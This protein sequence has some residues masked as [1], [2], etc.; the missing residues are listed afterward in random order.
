M[1]L[2]RVQ[3]RLASPKTNWLWLQT[4]CTYHGPTMPRLP[5]TWFYNEKCDLCGVR[6]F[7]H[8]LDPTHP[9]RDWLD[10]WVADTFDSPFD[11]EYERWTSIKLRLSQRVKAGLYDIYLPE[12]QERQ[13]I[14]TR[15]GVTQAQLAAMLYVVPTTVARWERAAGYSRAGRLPGR[16]PSGSLRRHYASVLTRSQE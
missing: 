8:R 15:N 14:R 3:L 9:H 11:P 6:R 16:E 13:E 2:R 10:E 5:R 7:E 1:A 12:A 4:G